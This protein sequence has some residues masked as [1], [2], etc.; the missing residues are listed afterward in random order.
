MRIAMLC[1]GHQVTDERITYKKAVSLA[2]DGHEVIVLGRGCGGPTMLSGVR[3]HPLAPPEGGLGARARMV[4]MPTRL[5]SVSPR[6][7]NTRRQV[8][9]RPSFVRRRPV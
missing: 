8:P 7:S 3:L 2:K 1:S 6:W 5:P 4:P 9:P